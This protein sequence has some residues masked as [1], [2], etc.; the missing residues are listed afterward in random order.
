MAGVENM[1]TDGQ[2]D[3]DPRLQLITV[4]FRD[5]LVKN[6][7]LGEN[8]EFLANLVSHGL[9]GQDVLKFKDVNELLDHLGEKNTKGT[10]SAFLSSLEA[11]G[12]STPTF[13][14][15]A[16]FIEGVP[17]A[18]KES[19]CRAY[20]KHLL[21]AFYVS[22]CDVIVPS[23]IIPRIMGDLSDGERG[24]IQQVS[25]NDGRY[26]GAMLLIN[27]LF[28][29]GL[30]SIRNFI[31]G[32]RENGN[33]KLADE[34]SNVISG[35][36]ELDTCEKVAAKACD[37]SDVNTDTMV[38]Q[39]V[40]Y[41]EST[42]VED[43]ASGCESLSSTATQEP[44]S[45]EPTLASS[46]DSPGLPLQSN[47]V[48]LNTS[49]EKKSLTSVKEVPSQGNNVVPEAAEA[50]ED[51]NDDNTPENDEEE[52]PDPVPI[53]LRGYQK[54][55]VTP[56]LQGKNSVIVAPTGSGKT[57]VA[58]R[59]IKAVL[60]QEPGV[61][62]RTGNG[63]VPNIVANGSN[64]VIFIVNKVPLVKQ[65]CDVFKKYIDGKRIM[66]LSGEMGHIGSLTDLLEKKDV[67]VMTAQIL[68]NSLQG[69][70]DDNDRMELSKIGL[71]ILDECHHC[72]KGDPY[73]EIMAEYCTLKLSAPDKE[74]PQI[75][76][77][78]AS[79]GVGKAKSR[80]KAQTH[81]LTLCANLDAEK[82]CTVQD[83][84][85]LE[86]L[87]RT[88]D[89]P[90]EMIKP[91]PGRKNDHF[92]KVIEPIMAQIEDFISKTPG[93]EIIRKESHDLKCPP[94]RG[95]QVYEQWLV[96][97]H[98]YIAGE[99][100]NNSVRLQLVTCVDH[101]KEYNN[102]LYINRDARIQDA[103]DHLQK[104]LMRHEDQDRAV[105]SFE[106]QLVDLFKEKEELLQSMRHNK[107]P[108]LDCLSKTLIEALAGPGQ[109][110]SRGILFCRTRAAT[111][112]LLAWIDETPDLMFLKPG[113]L[114]GCGGTGMTQ[115]QQT[116][117]LSLFK[118]GDHQ[119]IVAT[120]VAEEGLDIQQCNVVI[121][122]N[123]ISNDIGRVQA[124]GR[125]RAKDGKFYLIVSEELKLH[126]KEFMNQIREKIMFEATQN[127][128]KMREDDFLAQ[129]A[130]IQKNNKLE[131]KLKKF[132]SRLLKH[133]KKLMKVRLICRRC[134]AEACTVDDIK[135]IENAH[136]VVLN[137]TFE[138][139][140]RFIDLPSKSVCA[141]MELRKRIMCDNKEKKCTQDW[142]HQMLYKGCV[143]NLISP[144]YFVFKMEKGPNR[145]FKKW[146]D[147]P[148][149]I[150]K[151]LLEELD[152]IVNPPGEDDEDEES[153][154]Q[155]EAA[156]ERVNGD[157]MEVDTA[158]TT[159]QPHR[160]RASANAD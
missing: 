29:K 96:R 136:H 2:D 119:L 19:E 131:R 118:D 79:M 23:S 132:N 114:I 76:G 20:I 157:G 15:L 111:E 1:E 89:K 59:L 116:E 67:L 58:A 27:I 135:C 21:R 105:N 60:D 108:M 80:Y 31:D 124:Q 11:M 103:V 113:R 84:Q 156:N 17:K 56:A 101:L 134:G 130:E 24:K 100:E 154:D 12:E 102:S 32:L 39:P 88:R 41:G 91:V 63:T 54:E 14:Y 138:D 82:L 77:L 55:L 71:L 99:V 72:Q 51:D 104:Y 147:A 123:Y 13:R 153:D 43:N 44:T 85:N 121:R 49:Q 110:N 40:A 127:L 75:L 146:K 94:S 125:N 74:R 137:D 140:C 152:K 45:G 22:L 7:N 143:V 38:D 83:P 117:L 57:V 107:N 34:M 47:D 65:Q 53:V 95:T 48:N 10:Y 61:G 6:L 73:N 109:E 33:G 28:F 42:P 148:F 145:I 97:M 26:C 159:V 5:F 115:N 106:Q 92:K 4:V 93:G 3:G 141:D 69:G 120:S 87:K 8:S 62:P 66:G 81:I 144:K 50:E 128:Q 133:N 126:E 150:E 35:A 30:D 90:T 16:D 37:C 52:Q 46:T 112:A 86:E 98:K 68:V 129:I 36:D 25:A 122:Y 160:E 158:V 70:K 64:K 139:R 18:V 142:G 155:E 151:L 149:K 9:G 78:T